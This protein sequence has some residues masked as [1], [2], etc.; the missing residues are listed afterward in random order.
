M[1]YQ[2]IRAQFNALSLTLGLP[3]LALVSFLGATPSLAAVQTPSEV[4]ATGEDPV[5]VANLF[6]FIE[7]LTEGVQAIQTIND[8]FQ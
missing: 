8:A 4:A 3:A 7:T 6:D 1:Q 5:Q 2:Q